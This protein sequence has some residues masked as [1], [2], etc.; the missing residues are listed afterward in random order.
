M[1]GKVRY[2]Y[3][4]FSTGSLMYPFE[5]L[6]AGYLSD[7]TRRGQLRSQ[8]QIFTSEIDFTALHFALLV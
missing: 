8:V 2:N 7:C 3:F 5:L 4:F 6:L 1:D